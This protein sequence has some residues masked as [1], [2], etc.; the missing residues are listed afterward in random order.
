MAPTAIDRLV[1]DV[2]EW[3]RGRDYPAP[4]AWLAGEGLEHC[5]WQL[6][7]ARRRWLGRT[8][9]FLWKSGDAHR[10]LVQSAAPRLVD[11]HGLAEHGATAIRVLLDYLDD[12]GRFHPGSART[13]VLHKELDRAAPKYAAAMADPSVWRLAKRVFTAMVQDGVDTTDDVAVWD[14]TAEFNNAGPERRWEVL[15]PLLDRQPV[16]RTGV[17]TAEDGTVAALLPGEPMPPRPDPDP[18]AMADSLS[19][20]A[21]PLPPVADLADAA[22]E[23]L[24]IGVLVTLGQWAGAGRKMS[25]QGVLAPEELRS[26]PEWLPLESDEVRTLRE[27]PGLDRWWRIALETDVLRLS[28]T[29]VNPGGRYALAGQARDGEAD[30]A[31]LL[32][33]WMELFVLSVEPDRGAQA[34]TMDAS[35][36]RW[37][38]LALGELYRA[39]GP[40]TVG[41]LTERLMSKHGTDVDPRL[42]ELVSRLTRNEIAMVMLN[43]AE[44]GA[45]TIES[46]DDGTGSPDTAVELT[47]LGR[48]AVRQRLLGVEGDAPLPSM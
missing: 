46:G 20:P 34:D 19:D 10:L 25:K 17:I 28:R 37:G 6:L 47:A 9:P 4:A 32:A 43:A 24:L 8:Y 16:L 42:P 14:W 21:T 27:D 26:L 45:T 12:A 40:M 31:T 18:G 22:A 33:F 2:T 29:Q 7:D 13:A 5:L 3:S 15:G 36:R 41:A 11:Q 35:A 23:S 30:T 44:H 48:Y 39:N 38:R 1:D